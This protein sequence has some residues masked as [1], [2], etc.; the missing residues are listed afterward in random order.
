[1][2]QGL[3]QIAEVLKILGIGVVWC[4]TGLATIIGSRVAFFKTID[5]IYYSRLRKKGRI[6]QGYEITSINEN[7]L[8]KYR[9]N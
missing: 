2:E 6:Q 4:T 3:E 1:M 9:A 5:R 8:S 7:L